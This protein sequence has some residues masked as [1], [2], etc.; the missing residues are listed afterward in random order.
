MDTTTAKKLGS[1]LAGLA[2]LMMMTGCASEPV[3]VASADGNE[4]SVVFG[5]LKLVRNGEP[6]ALG[7]GLFANSA[8]MNLYQE[9]G[10]RQFTGRVGA[11]GEFS[12][13][14]PAGTYRVQ[15][16]AFRVKETV[17]KPETNFTFTVSPEHDASYLGTIA[18]EATFDAGYLGVHGGVDRF[19]VWDDCVTDCERRLTQLGVSESRN[20][21]SL[22]RWDHQD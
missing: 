17:M 12:W 15:S 18:L 2:A 3:A 8:T 5:K 14:L 4:T 21:V 6:V 1:G 13:E 9:S 10:N 11:D 20:D 19:T 16:I 22:L 7:D